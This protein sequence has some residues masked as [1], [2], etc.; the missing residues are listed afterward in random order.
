MDSDS[1]GKITQFLEKPAQ[2]PGTPDD[3][4][5]TYASMGNYVFTTKVL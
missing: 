2:P 5:V 3:P 1:N 4:D